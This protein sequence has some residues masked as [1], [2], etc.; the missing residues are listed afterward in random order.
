MS[1]ER[2]FFNACQRAYPAEL[3]AS[4]EQQNLFDD[5]EAVNLELEDED[6]PV[7]IVCYIPPVVKNPAIWFHFHGG[8]LVRYR[9]GYGYRLY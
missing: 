9:A 3:K 6:G 4:E 7:K 1:G 2:S 5:Y 8:A